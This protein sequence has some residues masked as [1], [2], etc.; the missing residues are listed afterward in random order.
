MSVERTL[1]LGKLWA[2]G[3]PDFGLWTLDFGLPAHSSLLHR[4]YPGRLRCLVVPSHR[5]SCMRK[6]LSINCSRAGSC[7]V[8]VGGDGRLGRANDESANT[9][10]S[11]LHHRPRTLR[12]PDE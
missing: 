9:Q 5:A 4:V 1:D 8:V 3:A 12:R 10:H 2:V 6:S 7:L 11:T